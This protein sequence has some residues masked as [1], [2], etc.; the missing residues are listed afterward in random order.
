MAS[1]QVVWRNP[2]RAKAVRCWAHV[3][4]DL[5]KSLYIVMEAAAAAPGGWQGLPTL[6]VIRG[7]TAVAAPKR[8]GIIQRFLSGA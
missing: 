8:I 4:R 5:N 1:L 2:N 3:K 7:R 6:E